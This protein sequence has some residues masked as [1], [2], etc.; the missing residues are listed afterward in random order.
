MLYI[1]GDVHGKI[2]DYL[3][4]LVALPA[5]A[6]TLQLGDMGLGFREVY[7]P[8]LEDRHQFFRGNHDKPQVCQK[9]PNYAGDFG[10]RGNLGL[11]WVAG[12]WS[13]DWKY[14]VPGLSWWPDEQLNLRELNAA[15]ELYC[16]VKP[17]IVVT[18]EAPYLIAGK[19]LSQL[20]V[21]THEPCPTD[22]GVRTKDEAYLRYKRE[23]G[24]HK[25]A[26]GEA[27]QAMFD[28]HKPKKWFFGHYHVDMVLTEEG[29]KFRCLNELSVM[30]A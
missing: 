27:L 13:I 24:L 28:A 26:T 25:T 4:K 12:G 22:D 6:E 19:V 21:G 18:H 17:E 11:F 8:V 15:Y 7:L 10:F 29:T 2:P 9:H 1:I 5:E 30:E 23:V 3:S 20:V 14:R 16:K